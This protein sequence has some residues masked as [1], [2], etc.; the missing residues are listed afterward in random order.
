[1]IGDRVRVLREQ[2]GWTQSHLADASGVSARTIQRV[3]SKHAYSGE[4]AMALAAALEID[5]ANLVAPGA[6]APGEHRPLWPAPSPQM[7][8]IIAIVLAAP[9]AS[10]LIAVILSQAGLTNGP[11]AVLQSFGP[12][13]GFMPKPWSLWIPMLILPTAGAILVVAALVRI[14]GRVENRSITVTG[15]ELRWHPLAVAVLILSLLI[16]LP[17]AANLFGDILARAAHAP[18]D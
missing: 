2:R 1:M 10:I 4:T 12:W 5:V 17:M 8:A 14:Y 7:A 9:G 6:A 13:L 3:E 16:V 15:V 11:M 18:L